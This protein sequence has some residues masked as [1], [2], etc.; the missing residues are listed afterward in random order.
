MFK[1]VSLSLPILIIFAVISVGYG[2][3]IEET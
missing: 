2:E 3:W 1:K